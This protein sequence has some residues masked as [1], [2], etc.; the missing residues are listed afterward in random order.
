MKNIN[1]KT[2]VISIL[3]I[4]NTICCVYLTIFAIFNVLEDIVG[5]R[6]IVDALQSLNIPFNDN[7][8]LAFALLSIVIIL[9]STFIQRN[10][11]N[12]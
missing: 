2:V 5:Y 8:A 1:K 3:R 12:K 11:S 7:W 4:V 9:L 6:N 10:L